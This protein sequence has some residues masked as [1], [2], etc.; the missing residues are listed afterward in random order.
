MLNLNLVG[1]QLGNYR[2]LTQIGRGGYAE[3]YLGQHVY[4]ETQVAVKVL[5]ARLT[6]GEEV[7]RF[8]DEAR[9]IA[10]LHHPH[11]IRVLDFG[12]EDDTPYFVMDYAPNG[13]LRTRYPKGEPLSL[14]TL[15]PYVRQ[16]ADALHYAHEQKLVHRDVKPEN[17]LLGYNDEVYLSDFGTALVVQTTGYQSPQQDEVIGTVAYMAPE[18][19]QGMARPASDQYALA[20]VVYEWLAGQ[21]LFHGSAMD[22]AVQHATMLPPPLRD[23]VPSLPIAVEQVIMRTLAKDYHQRF[24]DILDFAGALEQAATQGDTAFSDGD[25]TA[26]FIPIPAAPDPQ[27]EETHLVLRAPNP[28]QAARLAN[29]TVLEPAYQ[30]AYAPPQSQREKRVPARTLLLLALCLLL[31]A[32]VVW[33]ALAHLPGILAPQA[34]SSSPGTYASIAGS[35]NGSI[36]NTTNNITASMSLSIQQNQGTIGGQF[37]VGFPL[38]GS[39]PFTGSLTTG[40]H[41]QFTV[42]S[43][44]GNA[45]LFFT[46]S[47]HSDGSLTGTYC[48][49]NQNNQ[50][51]AQAGGSGTW[52]VSHRASIVTPAPTI[53]TAPTSAPAGSSH[54]RRKHGDN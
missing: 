7:E 36:H 37:T 2:L 19:F 31:F 12:M 1:Q 32:G 43:Y 17:M 53:I 16:V 46:G 44:H 42:Q 5:H 51:S 20:V 21:P 35:Y 15:L 41:V 45:P 9:T 48:S 29:P 13:T 33:L 10:R 40:G 4:L 14:A 22:I 3:V 26:A 50:C 28:I 27:E 30:P 23:S 52:N 8:R 18:L 11:I 24:P 39:G 38:V 6:E 25:A 54:K 49:L 47:R 34:G